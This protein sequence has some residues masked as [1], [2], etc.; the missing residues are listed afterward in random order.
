METLTMHL[1]KIISF[2]SALLLALTFSPFI[3]ANSL[4]EEE[5]ERWLNS[6]D[7][8]PPNYQKVDVNEGDL[9]FLTTKPSKPVHHHHNMFTLYK[10]SL[11]NGWI[12]LQQCHSNM[13]RVPRV[14]VVFNKERIRD[15]KVIKSDAIEK[16]WVENNTVQLENVK[17]NARL[18]I[19]AWSKALFK[20]RDGSYRL[21]NGPFMRKFLDGY[22]PIHVTI[23][24]DFSA[25]SLQLVSVEPAA[26][27]GFKVKQ[28]AKTV[29]LDA[30]F[31]GRLKTKLTFVSW[32]LSC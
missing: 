16:A 8:D 4:T 3:A 6:D 25:T 9:F 28:T 11:K 14:Q 27:R 23:D 18:C 26:Q 15:I 12:K 17:D 19:E 24:V 32:L 31:E 30:W 10:T 5:M 13:D 7:L 2:T 20:N 21:T 22:F 29:S 1:F